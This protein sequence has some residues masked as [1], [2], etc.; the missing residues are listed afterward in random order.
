[1]RLP[2][3]WSARKTPATHCRR[4]VIEP[5]GT[6]SCAQARASGFDA[7]LIEPPEWLPRESWLAWVADRKERRKPITQ[8]AAE[9]QIKAL[10]GYRSEATHRPP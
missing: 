9:A 5:S 10:D 2:L 6:I 4:T 7:S 8:R 3:Q 1:V